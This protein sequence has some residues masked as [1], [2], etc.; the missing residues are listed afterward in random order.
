MLSDPTG[1]GIEFSWEDA[2]TGLYYVQVQDLGGTVLWGALT[3]QT[4]LQYGTESGFDIPTT[5]GGK[6]NLD[7]IA[8]L[9][10]TSKLII[11]KQSPDTVRSEVKFQGIG[12]NT[13]YRIIV[14]A[15]RT[16]PTQANL[17]T[18]TAVA[19]RPAAEV[20]FQAE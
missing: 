14:R 4:K 20:K 8:P 3:T 11:S 15:I 2:G 7:L 5:K 9:S 18:A 13:S 10:L 12:K 19:I 17:V 6:E 1:A 16:T